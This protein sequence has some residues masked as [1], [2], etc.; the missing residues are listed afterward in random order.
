M[1]CKYDGTQENGCYRYQVVG[2]VTIDRA[3][4]ATGTWLIESATKL[5]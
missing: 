1:V 2:E 5:G 4:G 3:R